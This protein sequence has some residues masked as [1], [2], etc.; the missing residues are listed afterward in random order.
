MG[1]LLLMRESVSKDVQA[2][3]DIM[4]LFYIDNFSSG[5]SGLV[6][7][8]S[9]SHHAIRV[10]RKSAGDTIELTDG[11][12][13]FITAR[14]AEIKK[15]KLMAEVLRSELVPYPPENRIEVGLSVIRPT[16]MDW[17]VEKLGELGVERIV[18]LI[19]QWSSYRQIKMS[20]LRKVLISA[21]KQSR[22]FYLP[23][24]TPPCSFTDWI[25]KTS[26]QPGPKWITH[27][28]KAFR[29]F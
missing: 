20:H 19:C 4:E 17:G 29:N 1:K 16:R 25:Q 7:S 26:R 27:P 11:R 21:L 9:E 5:Q 8:P 22:Q 24:I 28:G 2:G 12:G 15:Q 18:P 14:I 6:L 10:L 13:N 3:G 23:E